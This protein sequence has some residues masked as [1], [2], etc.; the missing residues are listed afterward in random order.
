MLTINATAAA[1]AL[2]AS[3]IQSSDK[4]STVQLEKAINRVLSSLGGVGGCAAVVAFEFGEHPETAS[5]RMRWAIAVV[6]TLTTGAP[7]A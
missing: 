1:E 5:P 2:F 6:N 4:P 7:E 3:P